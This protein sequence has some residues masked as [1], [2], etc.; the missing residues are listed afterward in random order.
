MTEKTNDIDEKKVEKEIPNI[1]NNNKSKLKIKYIDQRDIININ[2]SSD[3]IYENNKN[4][5]YNNQNESSI[6]NDVLTNKNKVN[7]KH[8]KVILKSLKD[9][10]N[11]LIKEINDLKNKRNAMKDISYNNISEAKIDKTLHNKQVKNLQNIENNL[12]DKLSEIKR[13]ISEISSSNTNSP[14]SKKK[15]MTTNKNNIDVTNYNS[16]TN[17]IFLLEQNEVRLMEIE[18]Q[19]KNKQKEIKEFEEQ[20]KNKKIQ[21]LMDQREKEKLLIQKRKKASDE[22]MEEIKKKVEPSPKEENCLFYKM[23]QN[24][25]NN[26]QKL[27]HKI[28]TERKLKNIFYKQ[29]SDLENLKSDFQIYKNNLQQRALEQTNSMK[30]L[31]H[32]RSMIMKKYETKMM[33]TLKLNEELEAKNDYMMKL[34]R[35]GYFLERELYGK[36]KIQLPPID[37]KLK[38][39]SI[40][41]QIDIKTLKG[42]D[43]I[44]YVKEKYE[45]KSFKLKNA[46]KELDYGKKYVINKVKKR[47]ILINLNKGPKNLFNSLSAEQIKSISRDYNKMGNNL[48]IS[49]NNN[50]KDNIFITNSNNVYKNKINYNNINTNN[51]IDV[52]KNNAINN[53]Y[54]IK[55]NNGKKLVCSADKVRVKKNPKEINYLNELKMKNKSKYHKWNKYIKNNGSREI[56]LEGVQNINKQIESLDEKV[57]MGNELIKVKGGYGNNIIFANDINNMI[58]DSIKGKLAIIKELYDEKDKKDKKKK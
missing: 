18:K 5:E 22:I 48:N 31:W 41:N 16:S 46:I 20:E 7:N 12:I 17:K 51:K 49:N 54:S 14:K 4:D 2:K 10:E 28:N 47:K 32:S 56:D 15:N 43:R 50:N 57:N 38:Q 29:N 11:S 6:L 26:E 53:I 21:Y 9:K 55:N 33:R 8:N 44:N 13:Q 39:Q 42:K 24:Y 1:S 40:K 34:T 45:Q 52:N 19:Y 58:I 37:E 36:K 23:E 30:N 25:Q 3:I 35:K 27:L